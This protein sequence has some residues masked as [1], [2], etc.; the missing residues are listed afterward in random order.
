MSTPQASEVW[1]D[2]GN[3]GEWTG[4]YLSY[5]PVVR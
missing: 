3:E 1:M 4:L 5:G 2:L